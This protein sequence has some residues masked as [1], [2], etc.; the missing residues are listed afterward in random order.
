MDLYDPADM[1]AVWQDLVDSAADRDAR[2]GR[3]DD[4][5]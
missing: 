5:D 3:P 4:D 2:D 1:A